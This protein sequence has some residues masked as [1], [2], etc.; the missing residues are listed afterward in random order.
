MAGNSVP[1][2]SSWL[3][4]LLFAVMH[5][6]TAVISTIL[7]FLS[8]LLS[9]LALLSL[10]FFFHVQFCSFFTFYSLFPFLFLFSLSCTFFLLLSTLTIF[11]FFMQSRLYCPLSSFFIYLFHLSQ[12]LFSSKFDFLLKMAAFWII[13]RCSLVEVDR[14]FRGASFIIRAMSVVLV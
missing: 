11:P 6:T 12:T 2:M 4:V 5:N 8:S 14:R 3:T 9:L 1:S 7:S 10:F 13:G